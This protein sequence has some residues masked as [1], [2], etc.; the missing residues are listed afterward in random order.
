MIQ[1]ISHRGNLSG[2]EPHRENTTA[3]IDEAIN[4]GYWVE[5]D[6]WKNEDGLWLGHDGPN[7]LTSLQWLLDKKKDLIVHS[8]DIGTLSRMLESGMSTFYHSRESH[9]IIANLNLIW[10]HDISNFSKKSIIPLMEKKDIDSFSQLTEVIKNNSV[11]GIC[12]D[13]VVLLSK[14]IKSI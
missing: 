12:S 13:D 1:L 6:V 5:V 11:F 10:S 4:A 7:H 9:A 14:I 3:F 8:K 2:P